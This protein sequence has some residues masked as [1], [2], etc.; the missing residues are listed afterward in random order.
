MKAAAE[1]QRRLG[2]SEPSFWSFFSS[3]IKRRTERGLKERHEKI[4]QVCG[5]Y[6]VW[7]ATNAELK[8]ES[9]TVIVQ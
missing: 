2:L 6:I 7:T 8:A 4:E 5:A 1:L 9:R 3:R